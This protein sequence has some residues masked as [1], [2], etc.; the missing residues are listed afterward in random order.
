MLARVLGVLLLVMVAV[1]GYYAAGSLPD[2]C[3]QDGG[4]VCGP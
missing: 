1:A 2:I 4:L 3:L